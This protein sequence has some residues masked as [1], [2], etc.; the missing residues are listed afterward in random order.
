MG[1]VDY[2]Q[3]EAYNYYTPRSRRTPIKRCVSMGDHF[4]LVSG[5]LPYMIE[6]YGCFF[7][8]VGEDDSDVQTTV[9]SEIL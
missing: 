5:L 6:S 8:Q 7:F 3:L 9:F 1:I 4:I 2:K